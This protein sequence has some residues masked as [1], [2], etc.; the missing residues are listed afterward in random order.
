VGTHMILIWFAN[1]GVPDVCEPTPRWTATGT[2]FDDLS[3][4]PS[5]NLAINREEWHGWITNGEILG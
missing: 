1:R 2:G 3:V 5:I 4:T